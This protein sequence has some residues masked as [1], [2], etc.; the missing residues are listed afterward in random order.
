MPVRLWAGHIMPLDGGIDQAEGL[1]RLL[2]GSQT[3]LVSVLSGKPRVGKTS[4]TI[5]LA[6]ALARSGKDVLVLDENSAANNVLDGL[7]LYAHHD[8]LDVAQ[9]KCTLR[10]ALLGCKGLSVL[11]AARARHALIKLN[12][13]EQ[14]R[15]KHAL[16]EASGGVDVLLLDAAL[17]PGSAAVT[18]LDR[19]AALLLVIDATASGITESYALIKR[20]DMEHGRLRFEVLVNKVEGERAALTVFANMD[21]LARRNLSAR[22]Q[23]AGY[24]P[25]DDKLQR[26]TRLNK[27]VHDAFPGAASTQAFFG[28]AHHVLSLPLSQDDPSGTAS[29]AIQD[30]LMRGAPS[31]T[32]HSREMAHVVN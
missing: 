5:N 10:E 8:L 23:Y 31:L 27:T 32:R 25:R 4:V 16:A 15:L 26:A 28:L 9:G 12:V 11:P 6:A 14:R 7:G 22:L 29:L 13:D 19:G 2:E 3:R 24:I 21:G 20:L 30:L 17:S 18:S 1:R